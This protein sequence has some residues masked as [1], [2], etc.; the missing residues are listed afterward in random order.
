MNKRQLLAWTKAKAVYFSACEC[1]RVCL[2][3]PEGRMTE[4]ARRQ[5]RQ[6]LREL[7]RAVHIMDQKHAAGREA[8]EAGGEAVRSRLCRVVAR[9][10][11]S[12]FAKWEDRGYVGGPGY[13]AHLRDWLRANDAEVRPALPGLRPRWPQ[14]CWLVEQ[15][16]KEV[17]AVVITL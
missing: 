3:L 13:L 16:L 6:N 10:L 9:K 8:I 11:R 4:E 15:L 7:A 2:A 1:N 17:V 5:H 14:Y 12:L